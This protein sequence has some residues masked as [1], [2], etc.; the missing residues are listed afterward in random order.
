MAKTKNPLF[1]WDTFG[2]IGKHLTF[3]RTK[4]GSV[5]QRITTPTDPNTP[6]QQTQRTAF[7]ACITQWHTLTPAQKETWRQVNPT[8]N[9]NA[10]YVNFMAECLK[11]V[12]VADHNLLSATHPDTLPA[13]P[14]EGDLVVANATPK[15]ARLAR[16]A[17]TLVLKAT[18]SALEW[19]SVAFTELTGTLSDIQ[20]G[21]RTL[22]NAHAHSAMSGQTANDHHNQSHSDSDHTATNHRITLYKDMALHYGGDGP[23]T[24]TS[25]TIPA[26]L[27]GT[28]KGIHV[29]GSFFF[30]ST[31]SKTV[32]L[33]LGGFTILTY[34]A[35]STGSIR[36]D[37]II[38]NTTANAQTANALRV[39]AAATSI[40]INEAAENTTAD[41]ILKFEGN[42]SSI[43]QEMFLVEFLT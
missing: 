10:A 20:H 23:L 17:A 22:A 5:A 39:H 19:G 34:T 13:S 7:Q 24:L 35:T 30:S 41:L 2:N 29:F 6:A 27:L 4:S 3:R 15:W 38:Y 1:G 33:V 40:S 18:A 31:N 42:Q 28:N 26:N 8:S 14:L 21:V 16:G 43:E 32:A 36:I 12:P 37:A 9:Y 25:Y 11:G